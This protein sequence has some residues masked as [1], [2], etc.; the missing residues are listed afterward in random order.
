MGT[1]LEE[2]VRGGVKGGGGETSSQSG[3]DREVMGWEE[4]EKSQGKA[5]SVYHSHHS[6]RHVTHLLHLAAP[7]SLATVWRQEAWSVLSQFLHTGLLGDPIAKHTGTLRSMGDTLT[8]SN[9]RGRPH[10]PPW[11][12]GGFTVA[13]PATPML[14]LLAHPLWTS[15]HRC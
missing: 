10:G 8:K 9:V 13:T 6:P 2:E 15:P 4:V 12:M 7:S 1:D 3:R 11:G 14:C 5:Q